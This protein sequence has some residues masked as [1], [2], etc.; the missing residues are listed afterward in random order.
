MPKS[1]LR[2]HPSKGKWGGYN[3]IDS[4]C[5]LLLSRCIIPLPDLVETY[6]KM[7]V[8][9]KEIISSRTLKKKSGDRS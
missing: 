8:V 1:R 6:S 9:I 2:Q 3:V 7:K 5:F 4:Y